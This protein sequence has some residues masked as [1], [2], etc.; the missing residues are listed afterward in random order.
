MRR[1]QPA[2]VFE[3][4]EYEVSQ[5]LAGEVHLE[6]DVF[7]RPEEPLNVLVQAEALVPKRACHFS[8][9]RAHHQSHVENRQVG[10][11]DGR[12]PSVEVGQGLGHLDTA[13]EL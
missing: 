9:R 1:D 5:R 11:R 2:V 12:N 7:E 6:A 8:D 13:R 10:L 3:K 4:L